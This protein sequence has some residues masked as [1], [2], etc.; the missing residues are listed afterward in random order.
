MLGPWNRPNSN[1]LTGFHPWVVRC[2]WLL[3]KHIHHPVCE[4]EIGWRK[5]NSGSQSLET[6]SSLNNSEKCMILKGYLQ[7]TLREF[8]HISH[9]HSLELGSHLGSPR[10]K[11][12]GH[13]GLKY[14]FLEHFFS[15]FKFSFRE[16]LQIYCECDILQLPVGNFIASGSIHLDSLMN[17]L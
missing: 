14:V 15:S 7:N 1:S 10:S 2:V 11:V 4:D 8:F 12:K 17:W 6:F 3:G 9:K 16:C 5:T 13:G